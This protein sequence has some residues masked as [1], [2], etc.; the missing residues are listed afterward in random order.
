MRRLK[1]RLRARSLNSPSCAARRK[2][3]ARADDTVKA[4]H[5]RVRLDELEPRIEKYQKALET[6]ERIERKLSDKARPSQ[7][8][9]DEIS[10]LR[11]DLDKKKAALAAL[12]L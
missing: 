11:V 12:G 3:C 10:D 4:A 6:A 2:G 9:F 7:D 1:R 8:E 5:A